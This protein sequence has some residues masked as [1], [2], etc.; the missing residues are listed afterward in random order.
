MKV[1]LSIALLTISAM[2]HAQDKSA[3]PSPKALEEKYGFRDA[4]LEA[5]TSA[6]RDLVLV[7]KNKNDQLYH[8]SGDKMTVGDAQLDEIA[9]FFHR[10]KLSSIK[11]GTKGYTNSKALLNALRAQYGFGERPNQYMEKY[12]WSTKRV[13]LVYEETSEGDAQVDF[14]SK[15]M[16]QRQQQDEAHAAKKAASDL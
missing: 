1:L 8:R 9:Y 11:I 10:G 3:K 15:V 6:F 16:N 5:D 7:E 14:I 2:A 12:S 4:Q 13:L